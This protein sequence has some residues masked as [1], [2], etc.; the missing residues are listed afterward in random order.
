MKFE[1]D[2]EK[3][4]SNIENHGIRFEDALKIFDGYV[5]TAL[6]DRDDYDEVRETSLGLFNGVVVLLVVHTDRNGVTRLI[7]ARKATRQERL[8]YEQTIQETFNG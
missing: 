8:R 6:D 1:W 5:V 7:S 2:E 3:N 4:Q